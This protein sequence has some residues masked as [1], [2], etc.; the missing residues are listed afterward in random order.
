MTGDIK[1]QSKPRESG[2]QSRTRTNVTQLVRWCGAAGDRTQRLHRLGAI[3][4]NNKYIE[5][6]DELQRKVQLNSFA[7]TVGVALIAGVRIR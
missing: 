7:I 5:E 2:Y 6:P 4:S 1:T 3:L